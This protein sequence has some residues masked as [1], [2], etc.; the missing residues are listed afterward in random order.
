VG[1]KSVVHGGILIEKPQGI[2]FGHMRTPRVVI[3]P[4]AKVEGTLRFDRQVELFVHPTAK[5]GPVV[6][7]K[8]QSWTTT[9]PPRTDD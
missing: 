6:G 9:L 2:H 5:I 7:A 3:G 1:A 4:D 8:A